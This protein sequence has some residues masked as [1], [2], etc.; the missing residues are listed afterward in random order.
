MLNTLL[1]FFRNHSRRAYAHRFPREQA[2]RAMLCARV[3]EGAR[4]AVQWLAQKRGM[5]V[6]EYVARL[7]NDHLTEVMRG[8]GQFQT[9]TVG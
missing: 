2:R 4:N 8:H 9:G 6:S 5:S 3:Q 7:V 1:N